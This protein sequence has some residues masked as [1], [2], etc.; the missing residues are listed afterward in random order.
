MFVEFEVLKIR[1]IA[2]AI[3]EFC[4]L[5]LLSFV[6]CWWR[7]SYIIFTK[8]QFSGKPE[9]SVRNNLFGGSFDQTPFK[10]RPGSPVIQSGRN[11][12]EGERKSVTTEVENNDN[13]HNF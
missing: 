3:V 1:I 10:F 5:D 13:I 4:S 8:Y 12:F 9:I 2:I 6:S 11:C 7:I